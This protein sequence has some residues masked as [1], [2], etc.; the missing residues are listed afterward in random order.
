MTRTRS[1]VV[2]GGG[3]AGPATAMALQKAVDSTVYEARC[4]RA[5]GFGV[6]LTLACNGLDAL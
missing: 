2:I 4:T 3:I 1:A 5:D 6:L